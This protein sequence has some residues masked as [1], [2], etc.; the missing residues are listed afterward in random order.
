M[1]GYRKTLITLILFI[2]LAYTISSN[3]EEEIED[4]IDIAESK[5]KVIAVINGEQSIPVTLRQNEKVLWSGSSGNLGA[6]L[7]DSR[8]FVISTTSG[9]WHGL[10][11]N[12]DEPEKAIASLS[13]FMVLLV[14]DERAIGYSALTDKFVEKRLPLFEEL[15][16]AKTGRYVAVVITS[17]RA[18]GLGVKS[19]SFI[20]IRIRIKETVEVIKATFSKVTV[21]TSDRVLSFVADSFTWK[22]H[23][24]K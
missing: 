11:L 23:R 20:E 18:F 9:T 14:T 22:E 5:G 24:L 2:V 6:F 3:A 7:T 17:R 8:F 15:I 12:I 4:L 1:F 13:P 16:A 21:R 19:P 10:R